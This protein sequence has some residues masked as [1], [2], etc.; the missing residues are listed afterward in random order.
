MSFPSIIAN[1]VDMKAGEVL[2]PGFMQLA[3]G[4][5]YVNLAA[6]ESRQPFAEFAARIFA[7]GARFDE[8][9]YD[10]FLNLAFLWEPRDIDA[11][12]AE[13]KRK[14]R[15]PLL[16]IARDIVAFPQERRDIY[17]GLKLAAD[18]KSAD[19]LFEQVSVERE[20]DDPAVPGARRSVSERL[21]PDFDEFVAALWQKGLRFGIDV[22][23]VREAI[24]RDQAARVIVAASKAPVD[25]KDASVD[26]QTDLLHRDDAPKLLANGRMD[27]KHYRNRFPQVSAGTRLFKKVPRVE[28]RSGWNVEGKELPPAEVKDFDLATLAGPG[29]EV[30]RD[31]SGEYVVAAVSGF[32]DI[33]DKSGQLSIVDKIV[34][35][36]GVSMRTT[37][38]LSLAGDDYEEHGEVQ[39]KRKVEGHNMTFFADV[40][41]GVLSN[42]GRVTIKQNLSG[43]TAQSP[44]GSVVVEG[45]ASRALVEARGGEVT[46]DRAESTTVFAERVRIR[47]AI[48]CEI[49][50]SEVVIEQAEG[51]TIAARKVLLQATSARRDEATRVILLLP[52]LTP[53]DDQRK[54]LEAGRTEA[55]AQCER[56]GAALQTL[57]AQPDMKSYAAMAPRIKA[58]SIVLNPAQQAQWESLVARVAP[59][60]RKAAALTAEI[61]RQGEYAAG[62]EKELADVARARREAMLGIACRVESVGCDTQ[63]YARRPVF[64]E[65]PV[66]SVPAKAL[67]K[68]L[69]ELLVDAERLY[70]GHQGSAEW[71]APAEE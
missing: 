19:Y 23:A 22:K 58:K 37:G 60:L 70:T 6:L 56:L 29:T 63:I 11:A 40:F 10:A 61:K 31:G 33:D 45:A 42:G 65:T 9:D 20:E 46:I 16:R 3:D 50:A 35:R 62:A 12:L 64:G 14:G 38:D 68:Q 49:A 7:A 17:R 48:N 27:L 53:F 66:A 52:D 55:Q 28:G 36:E 43:G 8:L 47:R 51:C 59:T 34:S 71:Q 24:A 30:V 2:L 32:L 21:Y 57:A 41:G 69:Q 5:L 25:G 4:A 15:P 44:G 67:H 13:F 26:E 18:G 1:V 54:A 39:E